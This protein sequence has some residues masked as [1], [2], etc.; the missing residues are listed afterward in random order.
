MFCQKHGGARYEVFGHPV[1][2]ERRDRFRDISPGLD[3]QYIYTGTLFRYAG[4]SPRKTGL[5][6]QWLLLGAGTLCL[7]I[8][9]MLP[10]PGMQG[11]WYV[12]VPYVLCLISAAAQLWALGRVA[13]AG[14]PIRRY[15]YEGPCQRLP[16]LAVLSI[17]LC[18]VVLLVMSVAAGV[19][20]IVYGAKLLL[21]R[22]EIII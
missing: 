14:D 10:A 3:G 11:G 1:M 7:V 12:S 21:R 9:G 2:G 15:V 20:M 16:R 8:A 17:V 6:V 22:R 19:V 13:M 5:L 18:G 4:E